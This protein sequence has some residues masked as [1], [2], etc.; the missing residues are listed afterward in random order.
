M[1]MLISDAL[2]CHS[3][4]EALGGWSV[5]LKVTEWTSEDWIVAVTT[6]PFVITRLLIVMGIGD[7]SDNLGH[8]LKND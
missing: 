7:R 5:W 2:Y 4:A 1:A 3:V 6:L 8:E